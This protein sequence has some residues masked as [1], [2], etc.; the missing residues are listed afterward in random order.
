MVNRWVLTD[1]IDSD[2]FTFPINPVGM[3]RGLGLPARRRRSTPTGI[4][5]R[6]TTLQGPR[7][8]SDW[9]FSGKGWTQAH[10]DAL[11]AWADK[12]HEVVLTDHFLDQYDI[13][14]YSFRPDEQRPSRNR[15]LKFR[16]T[17]SA[18]VFGEHTP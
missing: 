12:G 1:N 18:L 3:Q 7:E 14:I 11:Q 9:S 10:W 15:P 16:Y 6:I 17:V 4:G 8:P 5:D 13:L 2:T